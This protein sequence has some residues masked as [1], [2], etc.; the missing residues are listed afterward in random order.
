[1]TSVNTNFKNKL[2]NYDYKSLFMFL[3][4]ILAGVGG[5]LGFY[6][7]GT[8][9]SDYLWHV[10]LSDYILE[11]GALPIQDYFSWRSVEMGYVETAHSW[12][13]SLVLGLS[14]RFL[15]N[16]GIPMF[17]CSFVFAAFWYVVMCIIVKKL[18]YPRKADGFFFLICVS[19]RFA[20]THARMHN[21]SYILFVLMLFILL[22]IKKNVK[23]DKCFMLPFITVL[24]ANLHGGVL[25]LFLGVMLVFTILL[26]VPDFEFGVL[27]H[28]C[29]HSYNGLVFKKML[30]CTIVSFLFGCLNPYGIKLYSYFTHLSNDDFNALYVGEWMSVKSTNVIFLLM[31]AVMISFAFFKNVKIDFI[32][33]GMVFGFTLF[34]LKH[35]RFLLYALFSAIPLF[36]SYYEYYAV[37]LE[38]QLLKEKPIND[39]RLVLSDDVIK[40]RLKMLN[41]Y[42]ILLSFF[43]VLGI[44]GFNIYEKRHDF[45]E[46]DVTTVVVPGDQ[47]VDTEVSDIDTFDEILSPRLVTYLHD[48]DYKRLFCSYDIGGR[49]IYFGFQSFVDSRADLFVNGEMSDMICMLDSL[50]SANITDQ[51]LAKYQFDGLI[52]EANRWYGFEN[53]L[54]SRDDWVL[55]YA[56]KQYV[57]YKFVGSYE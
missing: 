14:I 32:T 5:A 43:A 8:R 45:V 19:L 57:V 53:Y 27:K 55:D 47:I 28:T 9:D 52:F 51:I 23:S 38:S 26:L 7:T 22:D 6:L 13:G 29:D 41:I 31:I 12:L 48:N 3:I 17:F 16:L 40:K 4:S 46:S 35:S 49:L 24:C 33:Y 2:Q 18:F 39:N 54:A 42:T 34:S 1:M 37:Y 56:D 36:V 20:Y 11:N 25:I 21:M 15:H 30:V 50:V 10:V 44:L